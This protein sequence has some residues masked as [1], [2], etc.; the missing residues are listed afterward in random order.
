MSSTTVS[1]PQLTPI[2]G[3]KRELQRS[4]RTYLL[5]DATPP[6]ER[7]VPADDGWFTSDSVARLIHGEAAGLIGGVQSLVIQTLHPPT[8]AAFAD[9]SNY[10]QDPYGRL[11]RTVNFIGVTTFGSAAEAEQLTD[12][13]RKI[14]DRVSGTTPDG[15]PYEANDPHNLAWVHC[16]EVDALLRA[17]QRY[18]KEQLSAAD[19]DRYVAEMARVGEALGVIDAPRSVDELDVTLRA[20]IP[21]LTLSS[22]ARE[23]L[24]WFVFPPHSLTAQGTFLVVLSAAVN[25]LPDWARR[26]LWLP[27][28]IPYVSNAMV[29][30]AAKAV[31][32][33][34]DWILSPDE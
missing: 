20:Y 22:Q 13:V 27:P 10:K 24:R 1:P 15:I 6:P 14:H 2:A 32:G 12:V 17:Y 9:H 3:I 30:P 21:E 5:G 28:T 25:L 11:Q 26:K 23:A 16:T 29:A 4:F 18:G 7:L 34:I 8:M 31:V 19:A 33:T